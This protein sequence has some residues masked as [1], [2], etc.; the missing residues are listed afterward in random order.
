MKRSVG[1]LHPLDLGEP[2][3]K[4]VKTISSHIKMLAC[5]LFD[6]AVADPSSPAIAPAKRADYEIKVEEQRI[7]IK[8]AGLGAAAGG[9]VCSEC[10]TTR[11]QRLA[12]MAAKHVD[13]QPKPWEIDSFSLHMPSVDVHHDA[14]S[15]Q[16]PLLLDTQIDVS[17]PSLELTDDVRKRLRRMPQPDKETDPVGADNWLQAQID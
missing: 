1:N 4:R 5:A 12:A 13:L 14:S 7:I 9:Y 17:D 6:T 16:G 8:H 10:K 2:G 15:S 11:E 3:Q